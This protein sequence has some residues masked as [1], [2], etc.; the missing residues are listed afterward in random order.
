MP[1][2]EMLRRMIRAWL[3][4]RLSLEQDVRDKDGARRRLDA[5]LPS[6]SFAWRLGV[7]AWRAL[8]SSPHSKRLGRISDRGK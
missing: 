2:D 7:E 4:K 8:N 6:R 1:D 3:D 5:A